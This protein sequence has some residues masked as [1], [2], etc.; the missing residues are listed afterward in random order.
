[1]SV[2]V[3]ARPPSSSALAQERATS[4]S[5]TPAD[6]PAIDSSIK[7]SIGKKKKVPR[8]RKT[9][10]TK[11]SEP[12]DAIAPPRVRYRYEPY[13][14]ADPNQEQEGDYP[15]DPEDLRKLDATAK[16]IYRSDREMLEYI[17][18]LNRRTAAVLEHV[19]R[20]SSQ[21][22][23]CEGVMERID[24]FVGQWQKTCD[25]PANQ[26][27]LGDNPLEVNNGAIVPGSGEEGDAPYVE[28]LSSF[29]CT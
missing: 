20:T 4:L 25:R 17:E 18:A 8:E 14:K 9:T 1:M 16:A 15:A 29:N 28:L 23:S 10:R 21:L 11:P 12:A 13:R 3:P 7:M 22:R 27:V 5:N 19:N 24:L 26:Q 2:R 6:M